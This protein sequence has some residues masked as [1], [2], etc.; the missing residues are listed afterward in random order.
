MFA[1]ARMFPLAVMH[2]G[3][4][5]LSGRAPHGGGHRFCWRGVSG[6]GGGF[7]RNHRMGDRTMGNPDNGHENLK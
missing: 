2:R 6:G 7:E 1:L 5:F 3:T 4:S